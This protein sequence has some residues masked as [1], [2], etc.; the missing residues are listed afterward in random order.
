MASQAPP[1]AAKGTANSRAP[2][3]ELAAD[4]AQQPG[5]RDQQGERDAGR[6]SPE[7]QPGRVVVQLDEAGDDGQPITGDHHEKESEN[8]SRKAQRGVC[9]LG[10]HASVCPSPVLMS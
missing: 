6:D 5:E 3:H 2:A 4:E 7:A 9:E 10:H 1:A 8:D